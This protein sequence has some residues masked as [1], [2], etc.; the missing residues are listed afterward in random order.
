MQLLLGLAIYCASS[1]ILCSNQLANQVTPIL[2][3]TYVHRP[4]KLTIHLHKRRLC[5][6]QCLRHDDAG[7]VLLRSYEAQVV[8][9]GYALKKIHVSVDRVAAQG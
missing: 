4:L 3:V 8:C 6:E 7:H 5:K 1:Y 2:G 9:L